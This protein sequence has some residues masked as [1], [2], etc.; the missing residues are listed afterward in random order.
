MNEVALILGLRIQGLRNRW[1][2][3]DRGARV[4]MAAFGVLSLLFWVGL[5]ALFLGLLT[6]FYEVEVFGP[7]ITR[8]LLELF[9]VGMFGLLCFSNTVTALSTFFLSDDL[10][11]LLSLPLSRAQFYF[12]RLLDTIGQ[13]SWMILVFGMPLFLSYGIVYGASPMYYGLVVA[14]L[15]ALTVIPATIGV[16]LASVLVTAFPA[17]R[18]REVLVLAGILSLAFLFVMFRLVRPERLADAS[19]FDSLAAYVAALQAPIPMLFPPRWGSDVLQCALE[20]R[21]MPW[22]AF[23]LLMVGTVAASGVGRWLTD[24]LY[25]LGRARSQEARVARMARAGWLEPL[26]HTIA[27]RMNPAQRAVLIKDVKTFFRD[28]GQWSQLFLVGSIMVISLV[29]V[30]ALPVDV[31]RGPWVGTF[32]NVLAFLVLGLIGFVMAAV[33][34]RFQFTAVS[35]EGRGFWLVR[36]SPMT[37]ESYLW[38]KMWPGIVPMLVMG[39]TL[40]LASTAILRAGPFL[41]IVA[42]GM[43][44]A[45]SFGIAGIAVGMGAMY[46]DFKADSAARVASGPAG[47]FFMVVALSL[48]FL[49]IAIEAIPVYIVLRAEVNE[50]VLTAGQ[51]VGIVIA[52]LII[53]GICTFATVYPLRVGAAKL[54]DRELSNG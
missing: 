32:R 41:T 12:A 25:D 53:I 47:V 52:Q 26:L 18:M 44:L 20:G 39:E 15:G 14:V 46:P 36:S 4:L 51:W 10:E 6:S 31:V 3:A 35:T 17:R 42:A 24:R 9:L 16:A 33:A 54:W 21:P 50:M 45:L 48:V 34:A 30:A 23:A 28:P 11:L 2:R 49:V 13:S 40:A 7:I 22:L 1:R 19:S 27:R 43:A 29:S 5:F 8:K 37:A 38:A